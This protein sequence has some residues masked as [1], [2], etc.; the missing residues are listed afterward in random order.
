V[1]CT[2]RFRSRLDAEKHLAAGAKCVILSTPVLDAADSIVVRGVNC[3]TITGRERVISCGSSSV[4]ALALMA[5]V[6]DEAAGIEFGSM[7]TVHAYTGD[8]QLSDTAKPGLRWSRSAAQNIIPN[9]TWAPAVVEAVLPRLKGK[10]QGL[11]L[12]VPVP[13]GSNID[14]VTQLNKPFSAAEVDAAFKAASEGGLKGLMRYTEE[15]IVSSDAIRENATVVIDATATL[16][17]AGGFVKT[18]GWFDNGWGYAARM[19]ETAQ[20]WAD[21]RKGT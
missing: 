15:P 3:G 7:T 18:L 6:L 5:K 14:L 13:A 16:S 20:L 12:N 4:Q 9:T 21:R 8:Q 10:L 11:A 17:M 19:I 1:E 2:G